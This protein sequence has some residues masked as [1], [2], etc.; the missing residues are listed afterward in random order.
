M[1]YPGTAC[2]FG[3]PKDLGWTATDEEVSV[4]PFPD[5]LATYSPISD[6]RKA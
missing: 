6:G 3:P 2:V 1:G 5:K 4:R